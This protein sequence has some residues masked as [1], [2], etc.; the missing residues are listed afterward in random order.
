MK[1]D[2]RAWLVGLLPRWVIYYAVIRAGVHATTGE[3][4][5]V[6]TPECTLLE[7]LGR[8]GNY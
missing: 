3:W 1:S 6:I 7:V 2:L 5:H 4:G 8:W